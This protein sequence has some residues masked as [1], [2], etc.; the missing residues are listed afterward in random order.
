MNTV[1]HSTILNSSERLRTTLTFSLEGLAAR[2]ELL[3]KGYARLLDRIMEHHWQYHEPS[4]TQRVDLLVVDERVQPTRFLQ[5]A[6]KPQ[7]VLQLGVSKS[8]SR[9]FYL[10]W[11]LK[12]YELENELNRLG[13][14]IGAD[15]AREQFVE[16]QKSIPDSIQDAHAQQ[17]YRLSQWPKPMLLTAPGSMRLATMLTAKAM[18][19]EE[20]VFRSALSKTVCERFI[21]DMQAANLIMYSASAN[22]KP[23]QGTEP[24]TNKP[25]PSAQHESPAGQPATK[26][27]AQPGLLARIRMRLGIKA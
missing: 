20:L 22:S 19:L 3:F 14:L 11:P 10:T 18:S 2:E 17:H 5:A 15:A 26:A 8:V 6:G 12:P 1:P 13:R 21:T 25:N 16:E 9:P 23:A 7:N 27:V 24:G 4:T